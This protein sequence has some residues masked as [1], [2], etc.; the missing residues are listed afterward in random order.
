MMCLVSA[1][2]LKMWISKTCGLLTEGPHTK[3]IPKQKT[4]QG[5]LRGFLMA[6]RTRWKRGEIYER[7][8]QRRSEKRIDDLVPW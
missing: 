6:K 5:T 1:L 7:L 2:V 4:E 3:E 8:E